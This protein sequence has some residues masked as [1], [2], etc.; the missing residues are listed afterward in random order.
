MLCGAEMLPH[1]ASRSWSLTPTGILGSPLTSL[2]GFPF[3]PYIFLLPSSRP[4]TPAH[5]RHLR[6][7]PGSTWSSTPRGTRQRGP[8][9]EGEGR[10]AGSRV[11]GAGAGAPRCPARD[12][13]LSAAAAAAAAGRGVEGGEKGWNSRRGEGGSRLCQESRR[14]APRSPALLPGARMQTL[15]LVLLG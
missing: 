2:W 10:K 13:S 8:G 6:G 9:G 12:L 11:G 4:A 7:V 15:K 5:A 3:L 1:S 14:G